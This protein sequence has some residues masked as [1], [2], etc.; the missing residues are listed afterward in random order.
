MNTTSAHILFDT[1]LREIRTETKQS[2]I[3][4]V[5][6]LFLNSAAML[7]LSA[8][9]GNDRDRIKTVETYANLGQYYSDLIPFLKESLLPVAAGDGRYDYSVLPVPAASLLSKDLYKNGDTY[10]VSVESEGYDL[11]NLTPDLGGTLYIGMTFTINIP[12]IKINSISPP[13]GKALKVGDIYQIVK[14]GTFNFKAYG[15][16]SNMDGTIFTCNREFNFASVT[17]LTLEL[18]VIAAK[19]YALGTPRFKGQSVVRDDI[20]ELLSASAMVDVGHPFGEGSLVKGVRYRIHTKGTTSFVKFGL[21]DVVVNATF[22]ST[23]S[24]EPSWGDNPT[25]IVAVDLKDCNVIKPVDLEPTLHHAF[26]TAVSRPVSVILNNELRVYHLGNFN[27]NSITLS[28]IK[29]PNLIDYHVN[30]E[31][32]FSLLM[33]TK[34]VQRAVDLAAA[35]LNS[36]NYPPL[37]NES[38]QENNV[39]Q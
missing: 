29:V 38:G 3:P 4:E 13:K 8:L 32:E 2:L 34:I 18:R 22:V 37:K 26:G 35:S 20:G 11:T 14:A 25:V 7:E 27:V 31:L 17:N 39:K 16:V 23:K 36:T 9:A 10:S 21:D 12:N 1:L 30:A 6:D 33:Q 24:G 28:Y 15:A 19:P 5:K